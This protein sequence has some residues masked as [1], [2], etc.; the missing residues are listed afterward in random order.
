MPKK[1]LNTEEL[2]EL[3]TL[4]SRKLDVKS[5]NDLNNVFGQLTKTFLETSLET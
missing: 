3:S 4:Y 5:I 2:I 1:K